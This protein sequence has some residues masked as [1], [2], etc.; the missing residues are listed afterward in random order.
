MLDS[1]QNLI[2]EIT[3]ALSQV[4]SAAVELSATTEQTKQ[5]MAT[6]QNETTLVVTVMNQMNATV[7]D[8]TLNTQEAAAYRAKHQLQ[9]RARNWLNT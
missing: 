1:F 5:G 3:S 6:Q 4:A 8:V 7:H 2:I 9:Q